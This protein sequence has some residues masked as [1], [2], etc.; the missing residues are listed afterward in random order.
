MLATT[1]SLCSRNAALGVILLHFKLK[2]KASRVASVFALPSILS[3]LTVRKI[4]SPL[5]PEEILLQQMILY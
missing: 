1:Y 3:M 2:F 4:R 5:L